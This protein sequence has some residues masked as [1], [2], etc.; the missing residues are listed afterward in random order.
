MTDARW[1]FG[2][3]VVSAAAVGAVDDGVGAGAAATGLVGTVNNP[4]A[5]ATAVTAANRCRGP[6]D[7]ICA[8]FLMEGVGL[9]RQAVQVGTARSGAGAS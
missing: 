9:F 2:T 5:T 1:A 4:A 6:R 3:V 8:L 7:V